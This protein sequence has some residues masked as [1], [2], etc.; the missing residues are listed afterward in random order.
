MIPKEKLD[1]FQSH[2]VE[3]D[4]LALFRHEAIALN[5][6]NND[7]HDRS[8]QFIAGG[9]IAVSLVLLERAAA[10][11][12]GAPLAVGWLIFAWS[13][14]ALTLLMIVVSHRAAI[15][16]TLSAIEASEVMLSPVTDRDQTLRAFLKL[17]TLASSTS[18]RITRWSS[19][20]ASIL[21]IA[22]FVG[23]AN[24]ALSNFARGDVYVQEGRANV[25]SHTHRQGADDRSEQLDA[26][27]R[28]DSPQATGQASPTAEEEVVGPPSD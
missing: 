5:Q 15:S 6:R 13:C 8:V 3:V 12:P 26:E 18:S 16:N 25:E 11:S 9:G 22:G 7:A 20:S 10:V 27:L 24:F 4:A 23:G 14:W 2:G 1:L 28:P 17:T 21:V 19:V